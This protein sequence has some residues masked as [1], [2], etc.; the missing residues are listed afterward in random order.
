[1]HRAK[2]C[3]SKSVAPSALHV[4]WGEVQDPIQRTM[5]DDCNQNCKVCATCLLGERMKYF[6][7]RLYDIA[8]YLVLIFFFAN[9]LRGVV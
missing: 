3:A 1:M 5:P 4:G 2:R 6:V 9:L 8:L 7:D